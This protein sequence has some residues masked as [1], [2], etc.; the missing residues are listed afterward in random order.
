MA[1][2]LVVPVVHEYR[3]TW[4]NPEIDPLRPEII[5][6]D[7]VFAVARR[8]A[9]SGAFGDIHIDP[10]AIDVVHENRIPIDAPVLIAQ[11]EH[12]T[13]MGMPATG[14][15]RPEVTGMGALR[16]EERRV[17]KE[18]VSTCRSRWSPYH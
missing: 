8:I 14:G 13:G 4:R 18:C 12:R 3:S 15:C 2:V 7:E 9:R 11:V 6:I 1:L 16:S 17:G 5:G 10:E